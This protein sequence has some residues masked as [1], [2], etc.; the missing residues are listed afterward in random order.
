MN[1]STPIC[2]ILELLDGDD[3]TTVNTS[4]RMPSA[5]RDAAAIAASESGVAESATA[6][7]VVAAVLDRADADVAASMRAASGKG[8]SVAEAHI[9]AVMRRLAPTGD[10][11][12]I[13]SDP[14]DMRTVAGPARSV[15]VAV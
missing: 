8:L 9:G 2:R 7:R 13:T 10:V 1:L 12:V 4:M 5:L 11:T 14:G 6:L 15:I 3:G